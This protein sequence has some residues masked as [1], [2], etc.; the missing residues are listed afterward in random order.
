MQRYVWRAL[1][2]VALTAPALANIVTDISDEYDFVVVGGGLAGLVLGGRLSEDSQHS[3]LVLEAGGNGDDC[4]EQIGVSHGIREIHL[5]LIMLPDTPGDV[6][7]KS[8]SGLGWDFYTVPQTNAN[9]DMV[10]WPRGKVLGGSSAVNGLYLNRP[11]EIEINAWKDLLGDMDGADNWSWD[12]LFAAM[13]K[14]E[15]F[16]PPTADMAQQ[17]GIEWDAADHGTTGPIHHS[18]PGYNFQMNGDWSVAA[19]AAGLAISKQT[20]GGDNAGA[21]IATSAINPANWTRSYSRTGYLDPLPPRP[22]YDVLANAYVTRILFDSDSPSQNLTANAVEYSP[23]GGATKKTV[24]VSK[25]VILAAGS[26]MSPAVLMYSG[27]GPSD[28]LSAAGV[29]VVSDLPGVGQQLQDH[30]SVSTT[31]NTTQRTA[32][33]IYSEG[34][35]EASDPVFLSYINDA[36]AYANASLLF[37]AAADDL[38][39]SITSSLDQFAPSDPSVA[40]GYRA[41]TSTTAKTLFPSTLGQIELLIGNT[42]GTGVI[43]LGATLQHPFSLGRI[44]I[45]S[46]DPLTAPVIDPAYLTNPIDAQVLIAGLK[47]ARAIASSAPLNTYLTEISPGTDV[48]SDEEWDTFVRENAATEYHP[49][50]TCAMLPRSQGGVVDAQLRVYGL[51]N[52]RVADASVPPIEFSAHLMGSTYGI[53]EQASSI[54]REAHSEKK[55][56]SA[57][58]G[59]VRKSSSGSETGA[60]PAGASSSV[61]A[62]SQ[63]AGEIG[64][65]DNSAGRRMGVKG[66]GLMVLF[67]GVIALGLVF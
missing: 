64:R 32:A 43:H 23:D 61:L 10:P 57:T 67:A 9:D 1:A 58:S 27:V 13:K 46:S 54:I 65:K 24:K 18:Y 40:A 3:V 33:D 19:E 45:N 26:V 56:T 29:E 30:L 44:T 41:I 25:E 47:L 4:R 66:R 52:V 8:C 60:D 14:S 16:T 38:Y 59:G 51:A 50:S 11:G 62:V 15:T 63:H 5:V 17:A 21:Y 6:Y 42:Q 2:C 55:T 35:S 34:G 22:N 48:Q 49:S 7:Y 20:Y 39:S 28:V 31:W 37:G 36:I 12:S 53:A